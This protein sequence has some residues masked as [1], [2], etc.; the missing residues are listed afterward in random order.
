[1]NAS[2][3]P[4]TITLQPGYLVLPLPSYEEGKTNK[5]TMQQMKKVVEIEG[6]NA[7]IRPDDFW[8]DLIELEKGE[9]QHDKRN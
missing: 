5:K 8:N 7:L 4:A 2:Q 9:K 6:W 3:Y 1:M